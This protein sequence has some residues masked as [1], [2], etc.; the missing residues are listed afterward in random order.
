M[1]G[2]AMIALLCAATLLSQVVGHPGQ[3]PQTPSTTQTATLTSASSP[4]C[5]AID[6]KTTLNGRLLKRVTPFDQVAELG[7]ENQCLMMDPYATQS[8][9][10]PNDYNELNRQGWQQDNVPPTLQ[11]LMWEDLNPYVI[12]KP[13]PYGYDAA[14]ARNTPCAVWRHRGNPAQVPQSGSQSTTPQTA[15]VSFLSRN[16]AKVS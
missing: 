6:K 16:I 10:K 8:P 11:A 15:Q 1:H 2:I 7:N 13:W 9:W 4:A 14:F 5:S 3:R 12:S